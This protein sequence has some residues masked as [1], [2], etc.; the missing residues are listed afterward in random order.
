[1]EDDLR[2]RLAED[3]GDRTGVGDARLAQDGASRQRPV[4][5]LAPAGREVVEDG[6]LVAAGHQRIDQI[7]SDEPCSTRDQHPHGASTVTRRDSRSTRLD[8]CPAAV[9][10][11]GR[12]PIGPFVG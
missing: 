3:L 4:E 2:P 1:V 10:G 11:G 7:G 8:T 6:H 12:D 5:V 9:P